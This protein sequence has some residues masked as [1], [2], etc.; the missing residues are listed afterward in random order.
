MRSRGVDI[1]TALETRN[2]KRLTVL[3]G[4]LHPLGDAR[5]AAVEAVGKAST[6]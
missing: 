4:Y 6:V 5:Q 2:W 1:N 3:R